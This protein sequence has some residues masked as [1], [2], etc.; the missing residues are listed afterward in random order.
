MAFVLHHPETEQIYT[1]MLVN[2]YEL[3]YYG[4]QN[5]ETEE[6]A[7]AHLEAEPAFLDRDG[8]VSWFVLEVSEHQMKIFNVKLKND[9]QNLLYLR[10]GVASVQR[11]TVIE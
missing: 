7:K 3:A 1:R 10:G 11:E 8:K 5:W 9:P 4:V 6:E 2:H